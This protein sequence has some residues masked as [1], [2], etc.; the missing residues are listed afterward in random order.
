[1]AVLVVASVGGGL[2]LARICRTDGRLLLLFLAVILVHLYLLAKRPDWVALTPLGPTQNSRFWGIGNQLETLLLA[3]LLAGAVIAARR[4]GVLGFSAF[5]ALGLFMMTD[6]RFGSDGG[7]AIVL[8][9][10]LAFLGAR[11]LR[12][13]K[14]GFVLLLGAAAAVVLKVVS[15]NLNAAGPDHLRS[16]FSSGLSGVWAVAENRWPL[17]YLPAIANWPVVLPLLLWFV[18]SFAVALFVARRRPTRDF[19]VTLGIATVA[20]LLVNDSAMYELTGGVAVL[21][22]LVRFAPAPAVPFSLRSLVRV[23][24]LQPAPVEVADD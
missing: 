15:A 24:R 7:G 19:V 11:E 6:N 23:R 16:A 10:A 12:L 14:R 17:S 22:A 3:P 20:S 1:M 4:F 18:G 8:G 21:G 5:G 9:L 2:W 13:G